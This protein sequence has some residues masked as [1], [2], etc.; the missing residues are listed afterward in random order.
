MYHYIREID[1]SF[2][3]FRFLDVENFRNQLN[4]FEKEYGFLSKR[5]WENILNE[6]VISNNH[7]KVILTFDDATSCHYDY[8]FPELEKRGLWGIFYV[9][10]MP[11]MKGKLLDVHRIHLLCGKHNGNELLDVLNN[12]CLEEMI[13]DSKIKEFRNNTYESQENH[14]G[15]SQFKRILNYYVD[16]QYREFLI[17]KVAENFDL[18]FEAK[19]FYVSVDNL[20]EMHAAGN[21]IGSHTVTHP[22]MSKLSYS[23]Q[24]IE[25]RDSFNFLNQIGC[26]EDKTYCHPYGGFHTFNPDTLKLL[27]DHKV[28][29]SFNV[30]PRDIQ[31]KDLVNSLQHLPRHDCNQFP[32]GKAS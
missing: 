12:Y 26:N 17:D 27:K 19:D 22:V 11:Y 8:V 5:D 15:V 31:S 24:F 18:I 23:D 6:K 16:Y 3:N 13:P 9:P 28:S 7:G 21:I 20:K 10:T 32:H 29:Y 2:P 30:E 4:Y 14:C 1:V 25:I